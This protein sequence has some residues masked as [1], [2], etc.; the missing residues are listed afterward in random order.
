M[1]LPDG[2]DERFE[3]C[4]GLWIRLVETETEVDY[5][6]HHVA[7]TTSTRS[8]QRRCGRHSG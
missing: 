8:A 1:A 2:H 4:D 6:L 5:D 3:I 7:V